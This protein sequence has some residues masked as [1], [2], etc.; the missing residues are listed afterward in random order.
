ME[1]LRELETVVCL[2]PGTICRRELLGWPGP[3]TEMS[4]MAGSVSVVEVEVVE[5]VEAGSSVT[6]KSCGLDVK[7]SGYSTGWTGWTEWTGYIIM[8]GVVVSVPADL[9]VVI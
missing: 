1:N 6:G 5:V 8:V 3:N 9:L 7:T 4:E 2:V